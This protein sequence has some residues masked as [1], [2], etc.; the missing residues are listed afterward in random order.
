MGML[1][2][3]VAARVDPTRPRKTGESLTG[4]AIATGGTVLVFPGQG[5]RLTDTAIE[6]LDSGPA[7]ADQMRL[8][9]SAFAEFVD[10]RNDVAGEAAPSLRQ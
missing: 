9:D 4:K 8:C 7:F 2:E 6:L 1:H 5:E 3:M 10:W